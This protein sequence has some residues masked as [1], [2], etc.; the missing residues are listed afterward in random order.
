MPL[1]PAELED[2]AR[3]ELASVHCT[4]VN[5][6][7]RVGDALAGGATWQKN[8]QTSHASLEVT[9]IALGDAVRRLN[10]IVEASDEA[11]R[12]WTRRP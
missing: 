6:V 9:A 5:A 11:R 8:K 3:P 2:L 12:H 4:L 10:A 7:G 1:T